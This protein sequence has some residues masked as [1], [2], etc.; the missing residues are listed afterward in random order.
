MAG[1]MIGDDHGD[2]PGQSEAPLFYKVTEELREMEHTLNI[3][4][5]LQIVGVEP[6]VAAS[7]GDNDRLHSHP[8]DQVDPL[9][10]FRH[11]V[12]V[13]HPPQ[14]AHAAGLILAEYGE[15]DPSLLEESG[16]LDR[17]RLH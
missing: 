7:A 12:G 3:R 10:C 15:L 16:S 2:P 13:T 14:F 9:L 4:P 1:V 5:E 6:L 17:H 11:E 8:F